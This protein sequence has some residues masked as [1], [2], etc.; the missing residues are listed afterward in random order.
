MHTIFGPVAHCLV[1]I[2]RKTMVEK[3]FWF[4]PSICV[5]H[6]CNLNCSYCYQKHDGSAKM[7]VDTAKVVIDWIFDN[8]PDYANSVEVGFIGG[9]PLL[10]FD[11][12]KEIVA[13]TCSRKRKENYFFFASTNG[14]VLS[15]EMKEWF[16]AH[17]ESF[18]LGLSLDGARETHNFNR[19][20]SFDD[21][22]IDYFLTNY[23]NQGVK[24]TLT[25]YSLPRL[26]ENI[27]FLHSRGFK[28]IGGVNLAEGN[29]DWG[30]DKYLKLLA[31]Q[32]KELVD[33]Y[34]DNDTLEINQMLKKKLH[35]CETKEKV[36][37]K[38]CGTGIGCPFFDVDGKMYPCTLL[39]PMTFS[40]DDLF[41]I[42]KTDFTVHNNFIDDYCFDNC[43]I[44]PN[45]QNCLGA[46]YLNSKT[47]KERDK[48]RCKIQKLI[49]LFT[50]DLQA[51]RIVKNPKIYDNATLY[52]TIEA[53]KKIRTL[54]F[55]EF[56]EY[57]I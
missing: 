45:C 22:D 16:A 30:D 36:R 35:L 55:S 23:P 40:N 29:F 13:Y 57:L 39:A 38:S 33:F 8:I 50:A 56:E 12:L 7:T 48:R 28:D 47:F 21:I 20:N 15:E 52:H 34:V 41:E 27:K 25:E 3:K 9:E 2:S 17:K 11:L 10:E 24:M 54:Y 18:V 37:R 1:N 44:Y 14:T 19:C 31:P 43:Y 32:L 26:S 42:A 4:H 5:T 6:A 49:S 51:K 46:N 53:I